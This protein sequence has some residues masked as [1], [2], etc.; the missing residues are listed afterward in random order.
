MYEEWIEERGGE[1]GEE[2]RG[3]D[4]GERGRQG[5]GNG[6]RGEETYW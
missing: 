5:R 4:G 2:E 6:V 1:E 3:R